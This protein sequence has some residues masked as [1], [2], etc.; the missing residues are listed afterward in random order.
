MKFYYEN[1]LGDSGHFT[2]ENLVKAIYTAWNI[3]ADL[4]L[5]ADNNW[6]LVFSPLDCNELNS[7]LLESYGYKVIDTEETREIVD[8]KTGKF[9]KYDW[10]EIKQLI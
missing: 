3:D 8:I 4:Y 7:D 5:W 10:N 1:N 9:I 6:Q 2:E